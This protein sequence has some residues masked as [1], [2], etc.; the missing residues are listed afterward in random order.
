MSNSPKSSQAGGSEDR[1]EQAAG[2]DSESVSTVENE[3]LQTLLLS[4]DTL[5]KTT[6]ELMTARVL[7]ALRQKFT[8]PASVTKNQIQPFNT[9]MNRFQVGVGRLQEKIRASFARRTPTPETIRDAVVA[10]VKELQQEMRS[11]VAHLAVTDENRAVAEALHAASSAL[12]ASFSV[13]DLVNDDTFLLTLDAAGSAT[14]RMEPGQFLTEKPEEKPVVSVSF[15]AKKQNIWDGVVKQNEAEAAAIPPFRWSWTDEELFKDVKLA[16]VMQLSHSPEQIGQLWDQAQDSLRQG[17][18]KWEAEVLAGLP[19]G[20]IIVKNAIQAVQRN[21]QVTLAESGT[22]VTNTFSKPSWGQI[23]ELIEQQIVS[24]LQRSCTVQMQSTPERAFIGPIVRSF[25]AAARQAE[26]V[27]YPAIGTE[28]VSS[29]RQWFIPPRFASSVMTDRD[30]M[31]QNVTCAANKNGL[32]LQE[33]IGDALKAK[34]GKEKKGNT[35]YLVHNA[36]RSLQESVG[37][38]LSNTLPDEHTATTPSEV[39]GLW[40][41]ILKEA[42]TVINRFEFPD[43][44]EDLLMELKN[45]A[46]FIISWD[47]RDFAARNCIAYKWQASESDE[48]IAQALTDFYPTTAPVSAI[49]ERNP[50]TPK[51]LEAWWTDLQTTVCEG[52]DIAIENMSEPAAKRARKE[53]T[54]AVSLRLRTAQ[55]ALAKELRYTEDSA[56]LSVALAKC[57]SGLPK[58]VNVASQT[59]PVPAEIGAFLLEE[60]AKLEAEV[61]PGLKDEPKKKESVAKTVEAVVQ[62]V[63]KEQVHEWFKKAAASG[64]WPVEVEVHNRPEE[65]A[66]RWELASAKL[67]DPVSEEQMSELGSEFVVTLKDLARTTKFRTDSPFHAACRETLETFFACLGE[68]NPG[69][70]KDTSYIRAE[71]KRLFRVMFQRKL[72]FQGQSRVRDEN[73]STDLL[74]V[75]P[76]KGDRANCECIFVAFLR[77]VAR[78]LATE[79]GDE[80]NLQNEK[81]LGNFERLIDQKFGVA[82]D[83]IVSRSPETKE[84]VHQWFMDAVRSI[85]WPPQHDD[86]AGQLDREWPLLAE[87]IKEPPVTG[88]QLSKFLSN[89]FMTMVKAIDQLEFSAQTPLLDASREMMRTLIMPLA[90]CAP[91][92]WIDV[93]VL[94]KQADQILQA[95]ARRNN[96]NASVKVSVNMMSMM[97]CIADR[98]LC[99][100]FLITPLKGF[101][102]QFDSG[103]ATSHQKQQNVTEV[104]NFE[105]RVSQAFDAAE[106]TWPQR[107]SALP[108][109]TS[110]LSM[111]RLE[112]GALASHAKENANYAAKEVFGGP[113]WD[114]TGISEKMQYAMQVAEFPEIA[115]DYH[116]IDHVMANLM[117]FLY[118][119][120]QVLSGK[121]S[122]RQANASIAFCREYAAVF[123]QEFHRRFPGHWIA[124]RPPIQAAKT[125]ME[126]MPFREKLETIRTQF[127]VSNP[128]LLERMTYENAKQADHQ[129]LI[130]KIVPP[131][132]DRRMIEW[133]IQRLW[134]TPK[135]LIGVLEEIAT[136]EAIELKG[137]ISQMHDYMVSEYEKAFA[138]AGIPPYT[139]SCGAETAPERSV[140][141]AD[142]FTLCEKEV[143]EMIERDD[144]V[145]AANFRSVLSTVL[146]KCPESI[147]RSTYGSLSKLAALCVLRTLRI[148]QLDLGE[149]AKRTLNGGKPVPSLGEAGRAL[150][151]P[152]EQGLQ[153]V[154][155]SLQEQLDIH[156]VDFASFLQ[157]VRKITQPITAANMATL[158]NHQATHSESAYMR[159]ADEMYAVAS[160][161]TQIEKA[162]PSR[163]DSLQARQFCRHVSTVFAALVY[164]IGEVDQN[165][166][167]AFLKELEGVEERLDQLMQ[168]EFPELQR[169]AAE[170]PQRSIGKAELRRLLNT[171]LLEQFKNR[172][173]RECGVSEAVAVD[174]GAQYKEL[175]DS[176]ISGCPEVLTLGEFEQLKILEEGC[177]QIIPRLKQMGFNDQVVR[178]IVGIPTLKVSNV[179]NETFKASAISEQELRAAFTF[180]W[181]R[182]G[183]PTIDSASFISLVRDASKLLGKTD[184]KVYDQRAVDLRAFE[185]FM[186]DLQL[187]IGKTI[188]TLPPRLDNIL[189]RSVTQIFVNTQ[190]LMSQQIDT[191]N[192]DAG[193]DYAKSIERFA[194]RI[195]DGLTALFSSS[196]AQKSSSPETAEKRSMKKEE[197]AGLY[198]ALLT[199][200]RS[201]LQ[202]EAGVKETHIDKVMQAFRLTMDVACAKCP[203]ELT[204]EKYPALETLEA[205]CLQVLSRICATGLSDHIRRKI[206]GYANVRVADCSPES[207]RIMEIMESE[208]QTMFAAIQERLGIGTIEKKT[209]VSLVNH[210]YDTV[211]VYAG[212]TDELQR[213]WANTKPIQFDAWSQ[214]LAE[215]KKFADAMRAAL[216]E[217][218]DELIARRFTQ[219]WTRM[220]RAT[221]DQAHR[222]DHESA[223]K[224]AKEADAFQAM[225]EST[226]LK[227]FPP[228]AGTPAIPS[229]T[230]DAPAYDARLDPE[231]WRDDQTLVHALPIGLNAALAASNLVSA[232]AI[233]S[234]ITQVCHALLD[235]KASLPDQLQCSEEEKRNVLT[236][237]VL[238]FR[239]VA[240]AVKKFLDATPVQSAE[241]YQMLV[242]GVGTAVQSSVIHPDNPLCAYLYLH[243]HSELQSWFKEI[244]E[245]LCPAPVSQS[246]ET[247]VDQSSEDETKLS[248]QS[249]PA[250]KLPV[251]PLVEAMSTANVSSDNAREYISTLCGTLLGDSAKR[252]FRSLDTA[253]TKPHLEKIEEELARFTGSCMTI[254]EGLIAHTISRDSVPSVQ[255]LNTIAQEAIAQA[256]A[257]PGEGYLFLT[258]AEREIIVREV[259]E[260][261]GNPAIDPTDLFIEA[262][263]TPAAATE[264]ADTSS[265][266]VS[267][268]PVHLKGLRE[269]AQASREQR[270]RGKKRREADAARQEIPQIGR[271]LGLELQNIQRI[272]ADLLSQGD[273]HSLEV[274]R[275]LLAYQRICRQELELRLRSP[276]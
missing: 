264:T 151:T 24:H 115:T 194:K 84:E 185:A 141:K 234:K 263:T 262:T 85:A 25:F 61:K 79:T 93:S 23:L 238:S 111:S 236:P 154:F 118:Q 124:H 253:D 159:L 69:R 158:K 51:N 178:A 237:S 271:D 218:V 220:I 127:S 215:I 129:V 210:T 173:S 140:S 190:L 254:V 239:K 94:Q 226:L 63:S 108:E 133:M 26:K 70:W 246:A 187:F 268:V 110:Q 1:K 52:M 97:P 205:S 247:A 20:S 197:V 156:T 175:S 71:A 248:E 191:F 229:E 259:Y 157:D 76:S 162:A 132:A 265:E 80:F 204:A 250:A 55:P 57:V 73:F 122:D 245:T 99:Q 223:E 30:Q 192:H 206:N 102:Q 41:I 242:G 235:S 82:P 96:R 221:S 225:T 276:R 160:L 90:E 217:R 188:D 56:R 104:A 37:N 232:H 36:A 12:E 64:A 7:G 174:Y 135:G 267:P 44:P 87:Y 261:L 251:D 196:Q 195:D 273:A 50:V 260:H 60:I 13:D 176:I 172:A 186:H 113:H 233:K 95:M 19:L 2:S 3:A 161:E 14:V 211:K 48:K 193:V 256:L 169:E 65:I 101:C 16:E 21:F 18:E 130:Q 10:T 165:L 28:H 134:E 43:M 22:L 11:A 77:K 143:A 150:I 40:K 120:I 167:T 189:A 119:N 227:F 183:V 89:V 214:Y 252:C 54:D 62:P 128:E 117:D 146:E 231:V 121:T 216:P 53:I 269:T 266:T 83:K 274:L 74:V 198:E 207:L 166:R 33:K 139:E 39:I 257:V 136:P 91:L 123:G 100:S 126:Q 222:I 152:C 170:Q 29:E 240:L 92:Q 68:H 199:S 38:V 49:S 181:E 230:S 184:I 47:M 116:E 58:T 147:N 131:F 32:T 249:N 208:C 182:L 202:P 8:V 107:V 168:K 114:I 72:R 209:L 148:A 81:D 17:F 228:R 142:L 98:R 144:P 66:A 244:E 78:D 106:K 224:L 125:R 15:N 155:A 6:A 88:E 258:T 46:S 35:G 163:V 27:H 45:T 179:S 109:N 171:D 149:E 9:F 180:L 67:S 243:L 255:Q 4:K 103:T 112:F 213:E 241:Q 42:L 272:M 212:I 75:A 138:D 219:V 105:E 137:F 200:V 177:V 275:D 5:A 201:R 164:L 34:L 270:D 31:V 145:A 153:K 203:P 86:I 59:V